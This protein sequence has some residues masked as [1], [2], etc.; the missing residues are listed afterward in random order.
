M[1]RHVVN[2]LNTTPV[3]RRTRLGGVTRVPATAKALSRKERPR[4]LQNVFVGD[5]NTIDRSFSLR[6]AM[7]L[8]M[9]YFSFFFGDA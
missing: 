1:T 3:F 9:F 6:D 5:V 4:L 8:R 2:L 7:V